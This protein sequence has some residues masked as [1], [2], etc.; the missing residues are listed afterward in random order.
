MVLQEK[1]G[2]TAFSLIIFNFPSYNPGGVRW[3]RDQ[4]VWD[5]A[6]LPLILYYPWEQCGNNWFTPR[7]SYLS[8][9]LNASLPLAKSLTRKK[10]WSW[11]L[12]SKALRTASVDFGIWILDCLYAQLFELLSDECNRRG[13]ARTRPPAGRGWVEEWTTSRTWYV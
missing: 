1:F 9:S 4:I 11:C 10:S 6:I 5:W 8:W 7:P 3:E 12:I 2:L 13:A